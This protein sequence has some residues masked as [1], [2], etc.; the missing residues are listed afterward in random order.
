M[1][2]TIR[3][4]LIIKNLAMKSLR[5]LSLLLIATAILTSCFGTRPIE[6]VKPGN[7]NTYNV[8][9]LFEH[10]GCK[11]YRFLDLGNHVYFTNCNSNITSISNDSIKTRVVNTVIEVEKK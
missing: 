4:L 3:I 9:Y 1:V 11:V 5:K 8:H 7:N 6:T 2:Q 10:D